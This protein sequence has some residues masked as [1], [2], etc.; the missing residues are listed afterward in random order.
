MVSTT[1]L[2]RNP[3]LATALS[4]ETGRKPFVALLER[5]PAA[6][7]VEWDE[8][9]EDSRF[10]SFRNRVVKHLEKERSVAPKLAGEERRQL[11]Y[12]ERDL[13]LFTQREVRAHRKN[14]MRKL[15]RIIE[16]AGLG[17]NERQVIR[18]AFS[19][20]TNKQIAEITGRESN[21]IGQEKLR[22]RRGLDSHPEYAA[23]VPSLVRTIRDMRPAE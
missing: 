17:P 12:D 11:R 23:L 14:T 22:A 5:L 9:D 8:A 21:Q 13:M 4:E 20:L 15:N 6:V 18:M 2:H 7:M 19:L 1:S 16:E 10:Q 3:R